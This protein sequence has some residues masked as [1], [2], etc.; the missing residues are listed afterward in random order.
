VTTYAGSPA[1][2]QESRLERW[3]HISRRGSN[4]RT[5]I[6]AGGATFLTMCYILFVNPSII[7]GLKDHTGYALGFNQVL[8]MTAL[9]AGVMT[10]AMGLIANYPF[11]IA[12]GLGLNAFVAFTLV[13]GSAKLTWP[14][15]MGVIVVEGLVIT[16]LVI[17]RVRQVVIDAIPLDLKKAIGI[18][19]GLFILFIGLV[20]AGLVVKGTGTLVSI[21]PRYNTWPLVIFAVGLAVT[22]AMVAR[23]W[24]GAL[25]IGIIFTTAFATIVNEA[26]GQKVFTDGSAKIPHSWPAPDFSLAGNFSVV[27]FWSI[28]G[29]G[30]ALAIVLSVMLSDFFDTAGT[31]VGIAA[32]A[33]LLDK[34]GRLPGMT[35]VLL[36]D[37]VAAAAGG[38]GSVSSNTTLIESAAGVSAGGRTGL[39]SVVVGSLFLVSILLAPLAGM[40]PAVATAPVLVLVG[41][42][43]I[44]LVKE[45]D[46]DNVPLGIACLLTMA[47]MPFT[48]SITN[49]VGAGFIA[50]VVI[51]VL[52]GQTRQVHWM[53]VRVVLLPRGS[54]L[55]KEEPVRG[56][57]AQSAPSQQQP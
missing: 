49:G 53:R 41:Y 1:P 20:N 13:G 18:G 48:Y 16:A 55:N 4:V 56:R 32:E 10:L 30:T 9:V 24:K 57:G 12:S 45:I 3:F 51:S 34:E 54:R 47:I 23:R 6:I 22:A 43:M 33:G 26:K 36:V 8:T 7:A 31:T 19:I 5:E 52:A 2:S 21:T 42:F 35:G 15:A 37:S 40:V 14:D 44:R 29:V 50:Y 17:T 39:T 28:L 38:A 11:A 46:W 27:H 25:L